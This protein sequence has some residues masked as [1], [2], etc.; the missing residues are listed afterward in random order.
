MSL[1]RIFRP[2]LMGVI[3][4][5]MATTLFPFGGVVAAKSNATVHT[6]M[7]T[8]GYAPTPLMATRLPAV[9]LYPPLARPTLP[10]KQA[11]RNS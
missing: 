8:M 9:S 10:V 2:M 11:V 1:Q 6:S 4:L 5:L 3:A 7:R